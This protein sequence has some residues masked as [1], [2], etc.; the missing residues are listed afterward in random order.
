[1][2]DYLDVVEN[3][4]IKEISKSSHKFYRTLS[5][6]DD[7]EV[8]IKK[9]LGLLDELSKS[10]VNVERNEIEV[11]LAKLKKIFRRRNVEN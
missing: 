4:L 3:L 11:R 8:S 10:L 5:E 7:L 9:G 6:V 2:N 1:M